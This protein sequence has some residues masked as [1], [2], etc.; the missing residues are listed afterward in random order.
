MDTF[1]SLQ[2][3][4]FSDYEARAY[5]SLVRQNPLNGYELARQSGV[6]RA[7]IYS[8]LDK[9]AGRRAVMRLDGPAGTKYAPVPPADLIRN[10]GD[11]YTATLREA[12]AA[13]ESLAQPRDVEYVWNAQGYAALVEQ[14]AN[15]V[16]RAQSTLTLAVSPEEMSRL[17]GDIASADAR[18]VAIT[19]LCVAACEPE[20]GGCRGALFRYWLAEPG[21]KRWFIVIAD[22]REFIAGEIRSDEDTMVLRTRQ[23]LLIELATSYVRN[24][25]ALCTLIADGG[26]D[27]EEALSPATREV[28]ARLGPTAGGADFLKHLR[29]VVRASP[30]G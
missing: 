5:V 21:D 1:A 15:A 8:V 26:I 27:L 25:I 7:N 24:A 29:E 19:T 11:E 13:L 10:L 22:G 12:T 23:P 16:A 28:L 9:L 3:L 14:A 17:A 20:C 18:G 30:Q 4:G 2:R 6:P